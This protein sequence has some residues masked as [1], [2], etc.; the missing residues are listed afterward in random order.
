M[1]TYSSIELE[2]AIEGVCNNL[3]IEVNAKLQREY[4][5]GRHPKLLSY[6]KVETSTLQIPIIQKYLYGA[7][8]IINQP[9]Q[10]YDIFRL[11][12]KSRWP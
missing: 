5:N 8:T 7:K 9:C 10:Y 1:K 6:E 4:Q 11:C 2:A 3:G 12:W